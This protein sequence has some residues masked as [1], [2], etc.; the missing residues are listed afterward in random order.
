MGSND[1]WKRTN[2]TNKQSREEMEKQA[3]ARSATQCVRGQA[4]GGRDAG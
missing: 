2:T 1:E 3:G 4:D